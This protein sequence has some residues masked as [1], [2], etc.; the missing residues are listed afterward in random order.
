MFFSAKNYGAD[1]ILAETKGDNRNT[2]R[3]KDKYQLNDEKM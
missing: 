3:L 1:S 2:I